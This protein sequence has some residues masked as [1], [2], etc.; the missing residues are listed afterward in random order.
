MKITFLQRVEILGLLLLVFLMIY[1][2][3]RHYSSAIVAYVVE[4]AL[5]QKAP[6]GMSPAMVRQRFDAALASTPQ[7]V[8]LL[9][10]LSLS[11]YIEKVQKLPPAELDRLLATSGAVPGPG[12]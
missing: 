5:L 10:L 4:E 6:E 1:G 2:V 8:K 12:S 7:Q 9:K 3:A 11:N